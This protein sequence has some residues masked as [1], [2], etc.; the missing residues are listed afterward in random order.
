MGSAERWYD[1]LPNAVQASALLIRPV[2]FRLQRVH[3]AIRTE[4][5]DQYILFGTGSCFD[6]CELLLGDR[7]KD[8]LPS[9][10]EGGRY[11]LP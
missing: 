5:P 2:A 9:Y 8:I 1:W 11:L 4:M 6:P 7:G 10:G 3:D